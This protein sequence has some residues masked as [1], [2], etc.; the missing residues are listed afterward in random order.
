MPINGNFVQGIAK[1]PL[2]HNGAPQTPRLLVIHY[3]V[4]NTV[5]QAVAALNAA[6]LSY[7]ILIEKN[8]QAFQTRPF[9]ESAAHPGLSNWKSESGLTLGASLG[10]GSIG[11]CLMNK[12]F[13]FD[14]GV[15][16]APGKLIYNPNDAQMQR[17]E[18]YP[19]AQLAACQA[20][21]ADI[22]GAYPIREVVG[23]HDIAIMGKFDPGPLFDLSALDALITTAKPLGFRTTVQSAD[24]H[25]NLRQEPNTTS[26]IV[27]QLNNGTTVHVRTVVYGPKAQCI[28]PAP[29]NRKRYL[30]R[31]ASVA[32][33]GTNQHSGFVHMKGLAATP[34]APELAQHL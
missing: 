18:V 2:V 6:R 7:H 1:Q 3:S 10:R 17:W 4:T 12:G 5:A 32:L 28:H 20:I 25:L 22:I 30:T 13:D 31:W 14:A 27:R 21:A 26:A 9:T 24:G 29:G 8:G 15:A 33:D 11:I 23:H 16:N 19:A 34:L